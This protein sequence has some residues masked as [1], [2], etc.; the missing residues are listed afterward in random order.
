MPSSSSSR[1]FWWRGTLQQ[2]I[3]KTK[4]CLSL[5]VYFTKTIA[6]IARPVERGA[7]NFVVPGSIPG[8]GT[9]CFF[10]RRFLCSNLLY[11]Q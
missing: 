11:P 1:C 4:E 2:S 8:G 5:C 7:F 10:H 9:V 6:I 3:K